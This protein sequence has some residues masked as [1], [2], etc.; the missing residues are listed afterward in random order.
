[1]RRWMEAGGVVVVVGGGMRKRQTEQKRERPLKERRIWSLVQPRV[2][3][4]RLSIARSCGRAPA[5]PRRS[6]RQAGERS[7]FPWS[8]ARHVSR[9]RQQLE[10]CALSGEPCFELLMLHK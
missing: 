5:T 9:S 7:A 10:V 3:S 2:A 6:R 4:R 8:P 1:M